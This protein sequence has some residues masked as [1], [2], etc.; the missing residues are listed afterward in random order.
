VSL[1]VVHKLPVIV[2]YCFAGVSKCC[3]KQYSSMLLTTLNDRDSCAGNMLQFVDTEWACQLSQA[4][5]RL[6]AF[7]P[8]VVF[9]L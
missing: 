9:L 7:Y 1:D 4:A 3:K 5:I 8:V 6:F 2:K